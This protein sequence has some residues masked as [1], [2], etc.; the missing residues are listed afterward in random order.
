VG[1]NRYVELA[2]YAI[3]GGAPRITLWAA[4]FDKKAIQTGIEKLDQFSTSVV[5]N[6]LDGPYSPKTKFG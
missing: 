1:T 2:R 6:Y 3:K 5:R 4:A